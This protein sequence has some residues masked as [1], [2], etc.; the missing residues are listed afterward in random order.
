MGFNSLNREKSCTNASFGFIHNRQM[1]R[2]WVA[3]LPI[4]Q[5]FLYG[6]SCEKKTER[7]A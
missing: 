6:V 2:E 4:K 7:K 3:P 1:R 5:T